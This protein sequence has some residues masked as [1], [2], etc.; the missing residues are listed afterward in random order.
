MLRI[1]P[2]YL[3]VMD[4]GM[5]DLLLIQACLLTILVQCTFVQNVAAIIEEF[6]HSESGFNEDI[7]LDKF[8]CIH[9]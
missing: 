9:G 3:R 2:V 7:L 4:S 1:L 8:E 5:F 6:F